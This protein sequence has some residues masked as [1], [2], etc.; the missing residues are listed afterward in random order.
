MGLLD[1]YSLSRSCSPAFNVQRGS[2]KQKKWKNR[3]VERRPVPTGCRSPLE[4]FA[5]IGTLLPRPD[6]VPISA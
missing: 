4:D 5:V 2:S 3:K 1:Y 6:G